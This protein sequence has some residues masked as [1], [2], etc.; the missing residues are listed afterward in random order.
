MSAIFVNIVWK[1]EVY[2]S[3]AQL[4]TTADS[5]L[6]HYVVSPI[7][8][9]DYPS[10]RREIT[11]TLTIWLNGG[12]E[13]AWMQFL[14]RV[15]PDTVELHNGCQIKAIGPM[16]KKSSNSESTNYITDPSADAQIDRGLF[17]DALINK[18]PPSV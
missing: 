3:G 16:I 4:I 13:P 2:T 5:G 15:G 9:D 10:P 7:P 8:Q 12:E 6:P 18:V 17:T 1:S 14:K 11:D